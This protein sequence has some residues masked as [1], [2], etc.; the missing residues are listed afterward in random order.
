MNHSR[1]LIR[2]CLSQMRGRTLTPSPLPTVSKNLGRALSSGF[3]SATMLQGHETC[4]K[5]GKLC[6]TKDDWLRGPLLGKHEYLCGKCVRM[7]E[8]LRPLKW[9]QES[10]D[11][12]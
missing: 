3:A 12:R 5:C 7:E 1:L 4:D 8:V 6:I 9:K 10:E 11:T 2:E